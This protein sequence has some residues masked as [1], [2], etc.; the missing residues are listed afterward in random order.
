[1][2]LSKLIFASS[3]TVYSTFLFASTSAFPL[4]LFA[5][6]NSLGSVQTHLSKTFWFICTGYLT[7]QQCAQLNAWLVFTSRHSEFRQRRLRPPCHHTK[8]GQ[9]ASLF[10]LLFYPRKLWWPEVSRRIPPVQPSGSLWCPSVVSESLMPQYNW[11]TTHFHWSFSV[12]LFLMKKYVL[13]H[14]VK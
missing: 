7:M 11:Y 13:I 3:C 1:M 8:S 6:T 5:V 2:I 12:F 9:P 14:T 4:V 10:L